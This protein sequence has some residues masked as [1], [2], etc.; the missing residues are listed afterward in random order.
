MVGGFERVGA[1]SVGGVVTFMGTRYGVYVGSGNA[2]AV[3]EGNAVHENTAI[4]VYLVNST[5]AQVVGNDIWGN[6]AEGIDAV[7]GGARVDRI[8]L[9]GNRVHNNA[10]NGSRDGI[11]GRRLGAGGGERGVGAYRRRPFLASMSLP[12][13]R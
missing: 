3:I 10:T 7:F 8:E 2:D 4:G 11:L 5:R 6:G 1:F 12:A 13:M 9:V